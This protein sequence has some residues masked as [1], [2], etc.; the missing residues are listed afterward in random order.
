MLNMQ[1]KL[2]FQT[3]TQETQHNRIQRG[4]NTTN[5]AFRQTSFRLD[6]AEFTQ[7]TTD[8]EI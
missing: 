1:I 2:I 4:V 5:N 6:R 3:K 8:Y 7:V